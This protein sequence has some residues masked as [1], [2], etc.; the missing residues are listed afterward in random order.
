MTT[1]H[2]LHLGV[3]ASGRGSNLQ[4]I[5]DACASNHL[6]ATVAVVITDQPN[7]QALE[8]AKRHGIPAICHERSSFTTRDAFEVALVEDLRQHHVELVCLAGF[9]RI[10]GKTLLAAFPQRIIN[11]HPSLLPAFPGLKAQAQA[12]ASDVKTTGC[13][14]HL[15]DDKVDHGPII[16]QAEVPILPN[17][18]VETLSTRMLKEEHRLYPEAI[19]IFV[20]KFALLPP[21]K[22]RGGQEEL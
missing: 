3:L 21:L 13:T 19:Q 12:L 4:A 16:L 6:A 18:T 20:E 8:R 11:I 1:K 22:V 10:V 17:D 2:K 7:A 14:V 9:M 5:I 15:V